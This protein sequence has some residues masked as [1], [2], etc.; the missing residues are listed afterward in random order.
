VRSISVALLAAVAALLL[1][2]A[3]SADLGDIEYVQ[4]SWGLPAYEHAN[5][6]SDP[7]GL[8]LP[9]FDPDLAAGTQ[10]AGSV[11]D[12]ARGGPDNSTY[13]LLDHGTDVVKVNTDGTLDDAWGTDGRASIT[14]PGEIGWS[15][16]PSGIAVGDDGTV[17]VGGSRTADHSNGSN[18]QVAAAKIGPTGQQDMT[19]GDADH[20]GTP[21][22]VATFQGELDYI[23]GDD[24]ALFDD[25]V[26]IAGSMHIT[27]QTTPEYRMS[28]FAFDG[29]GAPNGAFTTYNHPGLALTDLVG[30]RA[31]SVAV[32]AGGRVVLAGYDTVDGDERFAVARLDADGTPDVSFD[33]DGHTLSADWQGADARPNDV[34]VVGDAIYVAGSVDFKW[35]IARYDS[36]GALDAAF[37]ESGLRMPGIEPANGSGEVQRIEVDSATGAV[38]AVGRFSEPGTFG[39]LGTHVGIVRL[40][41]AGDVDPVYRGG[42]GS[43]FAP[44]YI[45]STDNRAGDIL[46]TSD[47]KA[48]VVASTYKPYPQE[49]AGYQMRPTIV[50]LSNQRTAPANTGAP[51]LSG[52]GVAAQGDTLTVSDGTWS[53]Y[54]TITYEYAWE[55]CASSQS[56]GEWSATAGCTAI[57]DTANSRLL[58]ASDV[59]KHV[60]ALVTAVNDDNLETTWATNTQQV[61]ASEITSNGPPVVAPSG[62]VNVGQPLEVTDENFS[63]ATSY[64]YQWMRCPTA[65]PP[66]FPDPE[67]DP[68]QYLGSF[69]ATYT[70]TQEDLGSHMRV[71]VTGSAGP[72][73]ASKVSYSSTREVRAASAEGGPVRTADPAIAPAGAVTEG[74]TLTMT[75]AGAF[76]GTPAPALSRQWQRCGGTAAAPTGCSAIS[77]AT[78]ESYTTS[79]SDA[80]KVVRLRVR[81]ENAG[82]SATGDSSGRDV[83][84]RAAAPRPERPAPAPV[85]AGTGGSTGPAFSTRGTDKMPSV[86]GKTA[87]EAAAAIAA[88][89]IFAD[90]I[91][92]A[93]ARKKPLKLDGKALDPGQVHS[94]STGAGTPV[95]S[96]ITQK[97]KVKLVVEAGKPGIK[98]CQESE[99]RR[100]LKG[101]TLEQAWELL[102]AKRCA[103]KVNLNFRVAGSEDEPEVQSASKDGKELKVTVVLPNSHAEMDLFPTKSQGAFPSDPMPSFGVDDWALT[104]DV[105]N[106]F[107]VRV[108]DRYIGDGRKNPGARVGVGAEVYVDSD[109]VGVED[110]VRKTRPDTGDAAIFSRFAPTRPG[111]VIFLVQMEDAAGQKI[112]GYGHFKVK[113]RSGTFSTVSGETYSL[114]GGRASRVARAA[115]GPVAR[116]ASVN[117][118]FSWVQGLFLGSPLQS[119]AAGAKSAGEGLIAMAKRSAGAV[120]FTLGSI[121][122]TTSRLIQMQAANVVASGGANV[123][124][125]GGA[126]VVAAGGANVVAAGGA[127]VVSAG[128]ANVVAAG[129]ANAVA[130]GGA[131]LLGQAKLV[132]GTGSLRAIPNDAK[133][134]SDNGLGLI[135]DNGLGLQ[136]TSKVIAPSEAAPVIAAGGANL[137]GTAAGNILNQNNAGLIGT[138]AGN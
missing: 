126:N 134:L 118:L 40:D 77:G 105:D 57:G 45:G 114:S 54:G 75:S 127:N 4:G 73:A 80:G 108:Y 84:E 125:A 100:E 23:T 76:S 25:G 51:Q 12:T 28:A 116:A 103:G 55:R 43:L 82:G 36:T 38:Y 129:G 124:A 130:A 128:G 135:S 98:G 90:V 35:G 71:K 39:S 102:E 72:S 121:H 2:A 137:I 14:D 107:G 20:D 47:G 123:V 42:G 117:Q 17:F 56:Q 74:D 58:T 138:A 115:G 92:D 101:I 22:G 89:G 131:N 18:S 94:Q 41:A 60:R 26:V 34:D 15:F 95:V 99:F 81:A 66:H 37:G 120:Q 62:A 19:F 50:R 136:N 9:L 46:L 93:K 64:E 49:D 52:D 53:G 32:D 133:L 16:A 87:D 78:G 70:T 6:P 31:H 61:A 3:A 27:T 113:Q 104:A 96:S 44:S 109:R 69:G 13:L 106:I 24:I 10:A 67:P 132:S 11:T 111:T 79:S 5:A 65:D 83:R 30:G 97:H 48:L 1:P 29:T 110:E 112:F 85:G 88:A 68:C 122:A 91:V 7:A 21:D 86:L 119:L 33:D 59:D 63:G 8:V